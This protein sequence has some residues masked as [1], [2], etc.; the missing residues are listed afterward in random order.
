M[1]SLK[2]TFDGVCF[3]GLLL[4]IS[5]QRDIPIPPAEEDGMRNITFKLSGFESKVI[6]LSDRYAKSVMGLGD[7]GIQSLHNIV[8]GPEPQY[9]YYWSFNG[10]TLEPDIALDEEG[11]G[12]TFE[13]SGT[14]PTYPAGFSGEGYDAG[15]AISFRGLK[16][17]ELSIPVSG[18][19]SFEEFAFDVSSS[20]TGPKDFS[21]SYSID[22]G[23][24]YEVLEGENQFENM[25]EQ[26][27]N[28]Y[29]FDISNFS[30]FIGVEVLKL[31]F[32]FLSGDRE[33]DH[34]YNENSGTLRMDNIRLSGV[35]NGE[36]EEEIDPSMPSTLR[37][38]V[39]SSDDGSLIAQEELALNDLTDD[40][41]LKIKLFP[42]TY[43]VLFLA[44]RSDGNLLL[45]EDIANANEFYFGQDFD[46][47]RAVTYA[48][49]RQNFE[50]GAAD[51]A[52][53]AVLTRCFSLVTFDFTDLWTDLTEVKKIDV[54]RRH[55]NYLYMPYGEP[56]ELPMGDL[57]TVSFDRLITA[58]D[59]QLTF[60]QFIGTPV[61]PQNVSYELTAYGIDGNELNTVIIS[62]EIRNNVQ[63]RFSG[64][65]LGDLDRFSIAINPDWEETIEHAF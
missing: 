30:E 58:E 53:P 54:T 20:N 50:V 61:G 4:S 57:N 5:C 46:D 48:L 40:G 26:S 33:E 37:Y 18:V 13:A 41:V 19:E 9:L 32:E 34:N 64:R 62:E 35:Y 12:I 14:A 43:D 3:V 24:S 49:S 52:E 22:G 11:A 17:L 59:Y 25:G 65:L 38:Y 28:E 15:Q 29:S 31:K 23:V 63:L 55:E 51:I 47:Y 21:L 56:T 1:I 45:P 8:P 27:R 44:Y 60:H 42:G 10:E 39:F 16:S 36:P 7:V 6:P 2:K